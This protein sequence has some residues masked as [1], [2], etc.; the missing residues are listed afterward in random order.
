MQGYS[1]STSSEV[2]AVILAAGSGTRL[3]AS[4]GGVKKQFLLWKGFPL[5]WHSA[6]T[7]SHT[8]KISGIVFVFPPDQV[9]EMKTVVADLDGTDSLG[10]PFKVVA[11]GVRRQDSVFNGLSV[12]PTKCTH[13][14]VHDSARPFASG[15]LVTNIIDTLD[16]GIPAVIPAIEVTDTIKEVD[17]DTVKQT[18]VRSNLRAVQTPQ[19]FYL[20]IL[21]AAHKM[22]DEKGWDVTDDASMVEMLGS[23]L[24]GAVEGANNI[25][26]IDSSKV[27][28]HICAGEETN[29]K[30]TNPE[31]L[32]RIEEHVQPIPCV[33][34]GYDVHKYG[35]GRPM[36]LG[37]VPIAG[38]PQVIAHSDGDVLLHALADA[39]LGLFGGGDIGFHFP[40]TSAACE[41][42]ASGIIVTEVLSQAEEA[43][44]EIV[45]VDLT[46]I[47]QVPKL[48][49]HRNLIQKNIA[50]IMGLDKSQINVKAT[51]EERLGFTGEKKGIKAVAAV[52]GLKRIKKG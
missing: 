32:K 34:W 38:A 26:G 3:A 40:D 5:F 4:V 12:L 46:V 35:P 16:N 42:M 52:T 28:V 25:V 39:I 48:S 15:P 41:N 23:E 30:I 31:D 50:A 51:T 43:G 10:L 22:A 2:W 49:P 24:R 47:A 13:T 8:P 11:G 18:L 27:K 21:L 29:V 37:G 44:V 17:G 6:I 36:I 7:F 1:M 33:G 9:E 19:G 14:L 45:H 20:P